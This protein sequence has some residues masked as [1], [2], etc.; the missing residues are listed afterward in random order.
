MGMKDIEVTNIFKLVAGIL[1]IGNVQ[2]AE[3]GNYSRIAD[4][5]CI[6]I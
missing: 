4:E 3:N 1:H 5:Q 6:L 2:F